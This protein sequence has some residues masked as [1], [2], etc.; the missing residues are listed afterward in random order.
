MKLLIL[1]A[2]YVVLSFIDMRSL[3]KKQESRK[4]LKVY[5]AFML[6]GLLFSFMAAYHFHLPTWTGS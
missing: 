4:A 3:F 2:V 1:I 6:A 5:C